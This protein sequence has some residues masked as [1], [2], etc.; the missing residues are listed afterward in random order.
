MTD[1]TPHRATPELWA[2]VERWAVDGLS[3]SDSC[4]LELRARV[5]AL[6]ANATCPHVVSS[7]DGTSYC[8]LA[9]QQAPR[10]LTWL[11]QE[12]EQ[13]AAAKPAPQEP[14][15][16]W[17]LVEAVRQAILMHGD[18]LTFSDEARAAIRAVAEWLR[19]QQELGAQTW[20]WH[21]EQETER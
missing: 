21:L 10:P 5:E 4:I 3:D 6:E 14:A 9:E 11:E 15:P 12:A 18:G 19:G 2:S 16:A 17:P 20:A 7:D 13:M 8:R 1:T